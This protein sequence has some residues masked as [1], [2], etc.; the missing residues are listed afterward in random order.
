MFI[1]D[2]LKTKSSSVY[3]EPL[4]EPPQDLSCESDSVP[5]ITKEPENKYIHLPSRQKSW[6]K[7]SL[8]GRNQ[9]GRSKRDKKN[10]K[11]DTINLLGCLENDVK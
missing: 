7:N 4:I 3:D 9:N 10:E 1:G 6:S 11:N 8:H 5:S 2:L